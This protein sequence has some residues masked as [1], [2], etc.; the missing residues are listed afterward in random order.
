MAAKKPRREEDVIPGKTT[1]IEDGEVVGDEVIEESISVIKTK[2][3]ALAYE[4]SPFLK[5]YRVDT[6][7]KMLTVSKGTAVLR[8]GEDNLPA[9]TRVQ[10]EVEVDK[11]EFVKL[12]TGAELKHV[13][14]LTAAGLRMFVVFLDLI[15][16]PG[17][18]NH[19]HVRCT[20]PLVQKLTADGE[21]KFSYQTYNRGIKDL[22]DKGYIAAAVIDG[23][24]DGWYW[25]NQ[26][27]FYNGNTVILQKK[28]RLSTRNKAHEARVS[29]AVFPGPKET[30]NLFDDAGPEAF[31]TE[32]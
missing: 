19:V 15:G 16:R 26:D 29:R 27:R 18:M 21:E 4:E 1:V 2:A 14:N 23:E 28:I 11:K 30:M 7:K 12:F 31:D 3:G 13:Y 32:G 22:I 5:N 20:W 6:R 8:P 25:I 24:A 9:V 17:Q 10:Q